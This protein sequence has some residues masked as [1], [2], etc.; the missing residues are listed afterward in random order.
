MPNNTIT[1]ITRN[2]L[3]YSQED[4]EFEMELMEDYIEEDTN[5]T[6]VVY[7]VDRK[8]TQQNDIYKDAKREVIFKI[9]VEVPCLY[10]I[11]DT[12]LKSY[13]GKSQN[14]VYAVH[15]SL[16]AYINLNTFRKYN[17]DIK[18]GD[19][20]GI[21]VEENRMYYWEVINDGKINISNPMMVGAYKS[22]FRIIEASPVT[23]DIFK[24]L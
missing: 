3:F 13:D 20:I 17:F 24:G 10:E 22:G 16:K 6:I 7:Q 23:D 2:N 5:Q 11:Q 18:R 1:P 14:A 4:Y 21:M 19:Y 9:P 15:G 12:Q 8:S